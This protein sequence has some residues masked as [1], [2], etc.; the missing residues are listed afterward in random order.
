MAAYELNLATLSAL[1]YGHSSR[2]ILFLMV[3]ALVAGLARGF[4][5]FGGALIFM[6]L[7]SSVIDPK[8]AA[9]VLF[10]IDAVM[11][12]P[13][14]PDAYRRADRREVGV[15][16]AGA[17]IGVPLGTAVLAYADALTVRWSIVILVS[18]LL[19]LLV[20]GWRYH[21]RPSLPMTTGVGA[22]SGL[23]AG[24]AQVGGPPVVAYW[25]GGSITAAV[26]RANLVLYFGLGSVITGVN[27]SLAGLIAIPAMALAL[28]VGPAFGLGLMTGSRL[29]GHADDRTFRHICY[30][31]IGAAAIIGLPLLDPLLR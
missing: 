20:S 27:Y 24:A 22:L 28:V 2:E 21:G 30:G 15:M 9:A 13:M 8:L 5:G 6:P 31:L 17:L 12:L 14:I 26:V 25:L 11:A 7:A 18:L 10:L 3:S 23:F 19:A 4:S 16:L 1:L 29:F